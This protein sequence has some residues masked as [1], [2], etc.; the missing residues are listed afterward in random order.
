MV[1][2]KKDEQPLEQVQNVHAIIKAIYDGNTYTSIPLLLSD[3]DVTEST[4]TIRYLTDRGTT[5]LTMFK[6]PISEKEYVIFSRQQLD[7][8]LFTVEMVDDLKA[9]QESK[10]IPKR[11][12]KKA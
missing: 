5:D 2:L 10:A 1:D 8:T 12:T 9:W 11:T 7:K 4:Q 3:A 6:I